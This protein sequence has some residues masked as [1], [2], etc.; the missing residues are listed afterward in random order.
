MDPKRRGETVKDTLTN[1][2]DQLVARRMRALGVTVEDLAKA[3]IPIGTL[4]AVLQTAD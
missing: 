2:V 3:G 1:L 4:A